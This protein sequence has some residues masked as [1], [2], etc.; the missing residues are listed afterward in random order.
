MFQAQGKARREFPRG[1]TCS[2]PGGK[3]GSLFGFLEKGTY[4]GTI[5]GSFKGIYKGTIGGSSKGIYKGTI[6][7]SFKGIYKGTVWVHYG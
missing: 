6:G 1:R 5:G 4:K 7:G 3:E 2:T